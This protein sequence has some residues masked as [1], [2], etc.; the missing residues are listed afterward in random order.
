MLPRVGKL[1]EAGKLYFRASPC[2]NGAFGCQWQQ[3]S[4][5]ARRQSGD[6][7]RQMPKCCFV[8]L[9]RTV[10]TSPPHS[11]T[12]SQVKMTAMNSGNLYGPSGLRARAD[13]RPVR[14]DGQPPALPMPR[15]HAAHMAEPMISSTTIFSKWT[16]RMLAAATRPNERAVNP[17]CTGR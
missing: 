15:E 2:R 11:Q 17:S 14:P 10:P 9:G 13:G 7:L 3:Q 8:R 4:S 6:T 1:K 16:A 5:M 12:A